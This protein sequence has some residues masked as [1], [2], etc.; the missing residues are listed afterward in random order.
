MTG[1]LVVDCAGGPPTGAQLVA[2]GVESLAVYLRKREPSTVRNILSP[3]IVDDCHAHGLR[4][5]LIYEDTDPGF[6]LTGAAGGQ[7]HARQ[8]LDDLAA[9]NAVPGTPHVDLRCVYFAADE[10]VP[11]SRYP[12]VAAFLRGAAAVLPAGTVGLY[13]DAPLLTYIKATGA[14]AWLMDSA[15]WNNGQT[16]PFAHLVQT[17]QQRT[18]GG[19]TCDVDHAQ[20]VDYGQWPAPAVSVPTPPK[21]EATLTTTEATEIEQSITRAVS[22][23][24]HDTASGHSIANE[25][26][27]QL[28]QGNELAAQ[29][30]QL[31]GLVADFHA[32]TGAMQTALG[33]IL[34]AVAGHATPAPAV[35]PAPRVP[36]ALEPVA[37]VATTPTVEPVDAD[38]GQ[39]IEPA[40]PVAQ[41]DVSAAAPVEPAAAPV[42]TLV[43]QR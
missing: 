7:L 1:A 13:G 18:I 11:A 43:K 14:A 27:H 35:E 9:V 23:I 24:E 17:T 38:P 6:T 36:D 8:V 20:A 19:V 15:G 12:D 29:G 37:L 34:A 39:P 33:K 16:A 22:E 3:A 41:P 4:L 5:V 31:A 40:G 25:Q 28:A 10:D 32:A 21:V 26:A 42:L 30:H 2:G